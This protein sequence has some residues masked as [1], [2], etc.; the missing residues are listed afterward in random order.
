MP[1]ARHEAVGGESL[2]QSACPRVMSDLLTR[3][4]SHEGVVG[5]RWVDILVRA[6]AHGF[7][8]NPAIGEV[9]YACFNVADN[10]IGVRVALGVDVILEPPARARAQRGSEGQAEHGVKQEADTAVQV[11]AGRQAHWVCTTGSCFVSVLRSDSQ[12]SVVVCA[13]PFPL[14]SYQTRAMA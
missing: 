5:A 13:I 3:V 7:D 4:P 14:P 10:A 8:D 11:G 9:G 12:P 1:R 2:I 6:F